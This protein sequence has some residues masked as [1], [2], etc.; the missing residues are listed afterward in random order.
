MQKE[1]WCYL[2]ALGKSKHFFIIGPN[3]ATSMYLNP[4][5]SNSF[6]R[7]KNLNHIS[8]MNNQTIHFF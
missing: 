7:K 3:L 6:A 4:P 1:V 2:T 5:D 8:E